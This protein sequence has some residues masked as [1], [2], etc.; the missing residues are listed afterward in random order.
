M[1]SG[2]SLYIAPAIYLVDMNEERPEPV[3]AGCSIKK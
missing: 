3:F 2:L 1:A